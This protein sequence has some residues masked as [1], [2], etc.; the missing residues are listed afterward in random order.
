MI[1]WALLYNIFSMYT[2]WMIIN[3]IRTW[4]LNLG[5][6][7]KSSYPN[8]DIVFLRRY[9]RVHYAK[10]G[11]VSV[12]SRPII[13]KRVCNHANHFDT[14]ASILHFTLLDACGWTFPR[15]AIQWDFEAK[16]NVTV[17]HRFTN[18]KDYINNTGQIAVDP[19][20][21]YYNSAYKRLCAEVWNLRKMK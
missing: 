2:K 16:E 5:S 21:V 11:I 7:R 12:K 19:D 18:L 17:I 13:A 14:R 6:D 20:I 10:S 1:L 9:H 3:W 8:T 4:I 15:I